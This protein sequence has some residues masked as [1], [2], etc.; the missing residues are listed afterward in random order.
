[1]QDVLPLLYRLADANLEAVGVEIPSTAGERLQEV[2]VLAAPH[3]NWLY[4]VTEHL[5]STGGFV[6]TLKPGPAAA[7]RG[8]GPP[9]VNA[10]IRVPLAPHG[11][12]GMTVFAVKF[13]EALKS[14]RT[15]VDLGDC[16]PARRR[17]WFARWLAAA[18]LAAHRAMVPDACP[19]PVSMTAVLGEDAATAQ[20]ALLATL[21]QFPTELVEALPIYANAERRA[22]EGFV[23]EIR[24]HLAV[25]AACV[26]SSRARYQVSGRLA[27]LLAYAAS[28]PL[29]PGSGTTRSAK[30]HHRA[31]EFLVREGMAPD[32]ATALSRLADIGIGDTFALRL[33]GA[34]RVRFPTKNSEHQAASRG[35]PVF[36]DY[37]GRACADAGV[38]TP[39]L[40]ASR[41]KS[42]PQARALMAMRPEPAPWSADGDSSRQHTE[43]TTAMATAA[44]GG[45]V[46]TPDHP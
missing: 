11:W 17:A 40:I 20:A 27:N 42:P 43:R 29:E 32:E 14:L 23:D 33:V 37:W 7:D 36:L 1:M 45:D 39:G 44:S 22:F 31:A 8:H 24:M 15:E 19:W 12:R 13:A 5:A 41:T 18:S 46:H 26:H 28:L 3:L 25:A 2:M 34:P 30:L 4:R 21:S 9:F 6:C 35:K 16:R 38:L 10:C